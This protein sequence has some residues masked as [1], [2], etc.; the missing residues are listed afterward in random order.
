MSSQNHI[1]KRTVF[2]NNLLSVGVALAILQPAGLALAQEEGVEEV[3]VT[4]IRQATVDSINTKRTAASVVDAISATDIGKLPDATIAD[5]LQRV[6]GVQ[7]TRSGGEGTGVNIRGNSNVTTTLNG[8]QM[9][10]AGSITTVSPNFADIPS[11]MVSGIEVFKSAEAKNV[12]AGLAGTINLKTNRPFLLDDGFTA[13]GKV[14]AIQGSLGEETDGVYSGFFGY[15]ND[16]QFGASLN[17]SYGNSY[18]ADYWNGVMGGSPGNYAGWGFSANEANSYPQANVDINGDGDSNDSYYVAE[19]HQAA[20]R[21]IDRERTGINGSAQYKI[22]DALELTGDVFYTKLD[23]HTYSRAFQVE[24][25]WSNVGWT[26]PDA[27]SV[28]MYPNMVQ[29][30]DGSVSQQDGNLYTMTSALLQARRVIAQS[31]TIA[32]EKESLNTNLE[33]AFDNGEAFTGKLRWVHGEA[34]DDSANSTVDSL[35]NDG[36]QLNETYRPR[37]G[38]TSWANPGGYAGYDALMPDGTPIAGVKDNIPVGIAYSGGKQHWTL[39]GGNLP[40]TDAAGNAATVNEVFGSNL[41]RYGMKSTNLTGTYSNADMDVFRADG[42]YAFGSPVLNTITSIDVGLR[43]SERN[44]EK[45]GWIGALL[46]TNEYGDAFLARWKD[47]D[48]PAPTTGESYVQPISFTDLDARGMITGT[49]DFYGTSGLGTIYFV[50]PEAM[51]DPVAWHKKIYGEHLLVPNAATSY[52]IKDETSTFYIQANIEQEVWGHGLRGNVGLRYLETEYTITQSIGGSTTGAEINGQYYLFG[53]GMEATIGDQV[54]TVNKYDEVLPAINLSMDLTDDQLLRFSY[55]KTI[56]T[57]DTD[58]LGGGLSVNRTNGCGITRPNG[59][60]VACATS[61]DQLG[62]PNLLPNMQN[63][64]DLSYEWYINDSSMLSIGVFWVQG[65]T[66]TK[67]TTVL[68]SDIPDDDGVARYTIPVTSTVSFD[69]KGDAV[70]GMEFSYKQSFDFLPGFW[71]GFG[72]DT[73]FTYSPSESTDVDYYGDTAPAANNSEYQSNFALWYEMD[74][75]QARIAHN[76]RSEMYVGTTTISSRNFAYYQK[77]TNYIDAS[78]SYEFT[79]NITAA[80]Q[81]TNLTEEH[82]EYYNQWESNI[83]SAFYNERRTSLSLQVKY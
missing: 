65:L 44:V 54:T 10:S 23:E 12:V 61:A 33:L 56:G 50:D 49:N 63:N 75:L 78:L 3:I 47:V 18:L 62:N 22:N 25:G 20:N 74:G 52:D 48:S 72:I 27:D 40:I 38:D 53:P 24:H 77:P 5:S 26:T 30:L 46:R 64:V 2:K 8:E 15:N 80:L 58:S 82:Q 29:N 14:E 45:N 32:A 67:R 79:D 68:R 69:E 57:H 6:P 59:G 13:L 60:P 39:P 31:Q 81:I 55:T 11:T 9:L 19:G 43:Y 70:E 1:S 51:D 37:E 41:S 35:L 4:G 21:F 36:S 17:L 73:N 42:N 76:Y 66:N 7:I 83:D 71:S 28:S 16:N 34:N